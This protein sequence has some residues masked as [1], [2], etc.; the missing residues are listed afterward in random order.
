MHPSPA[1]PSTAQLRRCPTRVPAARDTGPSQCV[2][3]VKQA[4]VSGL[5]GTCGF[6]RAESRVSGGTRA[7]RRLVPEPAAAHERIG[8]P[9]AFTLGTAHQ[10][11][12]GGLE[13][14]A[15]AWQTQTRSIHISPPKPYW[16]HARWLGSHPL[17]KIFVSASRSTCTL[18]T[19]NSGF[20]QQNPRG[21]PAC[22]G[23]SM[24][25]RERGDAR[26]LPG[27]AIA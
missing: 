3:S 20:G 26:V 19:V 12:R 2:P 18:T 21:G 27:A 4:L 17:T 11:V 13:P 24:T 14:L 16:R 22:P 8:I 9:C 10:F 1:S 15:F 23:N 25:R 5:D 6:G 7:P